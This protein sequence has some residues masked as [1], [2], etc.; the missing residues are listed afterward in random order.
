MNGISGI[1]LNRGY[2]KPLSTSGGMGV[3]LLTNPDLPCSILTAP[4]GV[5]PPEVSVSVGEDQVVPHTLKLMER[6]INT[7]ISALA[8]YC[9]TS[10]MRKTGKGDY[11]EAKGD[12]RV[13]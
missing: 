4:R 2:P 7:G 6:T 1:D 8:I 3:A 5:M 10:N 12:C 13:C 9:R 11:R